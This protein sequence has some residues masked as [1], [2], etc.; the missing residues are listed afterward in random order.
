MSERCFSCGG[1][2]EP[3]PDGAT[4]KYML[5][6]P[7]C[8]A[9]FGEVLA[10]EYSNPRLFGSSHRLTVDA[11]ACQHPGDPA[12][13]R[14]VQSVWVH[15]TSLWLVLEAGASHNLATQ[16]LKT[17]A[18]RTFDALPEAPTHFEHTHSDVLKAP[19]ADHE[20][21]AQAWAKASLAGWAAIHDRLEEF[22]REILN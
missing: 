11:Y 7:G 6:T 14:A 4:H 20:A 9:A 18:G 17:L 12:D 21:Q 19:L 16:A 22:S 5:S 1:A 3:G 13:R 8:W 2:F 15:A 10:R